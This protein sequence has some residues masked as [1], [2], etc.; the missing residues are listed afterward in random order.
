MRMEN[1]QESQNVEDRR[2]SGFRP[3]HGIGL[4]TIAVALIAGWIFGINPLTVL[5]LLSGGSVSDSSAPPS[6]E[7]NANAKFASQVLHS[8][9]VVWGRVFMEMGR[10]YEQPTLTLFSDAT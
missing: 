8:T 6:P 4:G 9:E 3:A 10:S 1:E 5:G 2:G 7:D